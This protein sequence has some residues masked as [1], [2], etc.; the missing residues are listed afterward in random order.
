ML[1]K[2][3]FVVSVFFFLSGC[4]FFDSI[5]TSISGETDFDG[6]VTSVTF[7]STV[8]NV[9][10]NES[11][12]LQLTLS[13]SSNQGKC[14]V[15]WE[16]DENFI[17]VKSDNFG[18]V[19]TGLTA[20]STYIKAKCNG[21]VATCMIS[22]LA[23]GS[24][25]ET[26]PYIYSNYSVI[27][28]KPGDAA[29][30]ISSL[31]GGSISD[32]EFF[33]WS[34]KDS[35]VADISYSRNNCIITAKKTGSTQLVCSHPD[36]KYD[37]SFVIY[38][39]A[40]KM[41]ETYIT[42]DYNVVTINKNE[43]SSKSITVD[44]VNPLNAA[45]KNG[46]VWNYA[47]E[48]SKKIIS[49]T[50][51]LNE[52]VI[53]PQS[54]GIAKII[55]NHENSQYSLEIIIRVC[56]IVKNTYIGLTQTSLI[57][58][59][60]DT[61]YTVYASVENYDGYADA[62]AF[63]WEFP[64]EAEE[65][66]DFSWAGNSVRIQGKKNGCVKIKVSHPLS[67]YSRNLL[68]ILQNQ[69]GSAKDASMYI[70]TTQNYVQTQ[71]GKEPTVINCTLVGG[72][73]GEDD[74]GD[75]SS[76][77]TWWI[78]GGEN[79]GIIEVQAVTGFVKDTSA[80]SAATSGN[81]CSAS[82]Q[83]NPV[84]EGTVK[85]YI[86]HP[87]CL[88]ETEITVKVFA[89]SAI[90]N[91]L[92]ITT[93]ESLVR[94]V[95]GNST[96]IT[97][98][99]R[100]GS[101]GDE[102]NIQWSSSDEEK[103]FLSN[104]TGSQTELI[105]YSGTGNGQTYVTA[106]LE[107]A[108]SDKK[109]L[110]LTADTE[111]ELY[112]MKGIYADS[113]YVRVTSGETKEISVEGFGLVSTDIISWASSDSSLCVVTAESS[114]ANRCIARVTGINEGKVNVTAKIGTSASVVF[115]VTVLKEGESSEIYDE[116]AGY[117]TTALNAVVLESEDDS[118]ELS[119]TG[120]NITDADMALY[121]VWTSSDVNSSEEESIFN[122]Y[123]S[124]G[125][126]V[127]LTANKKGKANLTVK[128]KNAVN[129]L[130]INAKCG[131]LYEW[132]DDYVIYIVSDEDVVNIVNGQTYTIGCSLVNTTSSGSF[133]WKVIRGSDNVDI[134][135]LASGTCSITGKQ[136]GQ[137]IIEVTNTLSGGITK[138]ILIN[139]SNTEEEL[140]GF[141]YLTTEQNVV[142]VG[143]QS[144]SSISVSIVNSDS[145][146]LSG[147][148]WRSTNE[149]VA[150]VVG[151]GSVAV[152]YGKAIGT[153]KIIV[154]N[155]E[156]C[157]Y[158]LE[159]ICNVV[160]PVAVKADPYISCNNI[161]T[162][163]VGGDYATVAAELVGGTD[164]DSQ[165]F[166][167]S[168]TDSAVA[169][170]YSSNDS[171]QIKALKEGVTQ[172]IISHPKA[173]VPRT[174]LVICEPKIT[175]NCYIS[176]AESIIKMS[177]SDEAKTI[178][179]ELVNGDAQ[180]VYDFKWWADSYDKI[181]M[182]YTGSSCLI[183]PLSSGTVT[184]H[185]SHPK[186]ANQ[187]DII[188]YIS[189]YTYFAF[190]ASSVELT[191]GSSYFINMEVP[192]TNVECEIAYSSS[193]NSVCTVFGNSSVCTL[194]PGDVEQG[195]SKT[196]VITATLQTKGGVKQAQAQL[197]VSVTGKDATKPYIALYPDSLSTIITMNKG[198]KKNL[199]AVLYGS[200]VVD[201][202]YA[203][204]NWSVN[205]G[206]GTFI[207]FVA[208]KNT[209]SSV[210]IEAVA[211][212]KTTITVTHSE[213]KNPL[214]LYV[215][216]NGVSEPTV[217]L[218]YTELPVYIGEN[219]QTLTAT[220]QNDAG[221]ELIWTV[222]NDEDGSNSQ[223]YFDFTV[224][225]SK[226]SIYA[227]NPGT[228]TV[229]VSLPSGS[230]ASCRVRILESE[231]IVF[232][233][234]DDEENCTYDESAKTI[235]ED[236][237]TKKY[238]T[239]LQLYPGQS[240][241]LHWE[242]VPAKDTITKWYRSDSNYFEIN[243]VSAGYIDSWTD[244]VSKKTY[245][246]PDG[247]GTVIL[248]GKT[249]EGTAMLQVTTASNQTASVSVTNSYNYLFTTS[250]TI[251]SATP[252]EV[253]KDKTILYVDYELR[254]ACSKIYVTNKTVTEAG[255]N[256]VLESG[257]ASYDK[258]QQ[259]WV[260]ENHETTEETS[261]TG[262]VKGKLKFAIE[263][264]ANCT[265]EVF[266]RN[267]N[268]VSSGSASSSTS[269]DDFGKSNIK[270]QVYYSSHTFI[271]EIVKQVP[272]YN[273]TV[274]DSDEKNSMYSEFDSQSNTFFLGDGE[275]LS[276]TIKVD[277]EKEP[278]S[279]VLITGIKF[280]PVN[281]SQ[282]KDSSD[283]SSGKS[284]YELVF[285]EENG[286]VVNEHPFVLYHNTDYALI[287]YST[288]GSSFEKKTKCYKIPDGDSRA[289]SENYNETVKETSFVGYLTVSYFNYAKG[290]GEN[291]Y[292]FPVYVRVRNCPCSINNYYLRSATW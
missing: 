39:Y 249:N 265:V 86:S 84:G 225:G 57:I 45:Y 112:S 68:V 50:S 18:A 58:D 232:F 60:S 139:V 246:Y 276:G 5:E 237:R 97:A 118:A 193:D 48:E 147:Y 287:Y 140:N 239:F 155:N 278:Y 23:D 183:K 63:I 190:A 126:S 12:Y 260:I 172:V 248:T 186:A 242:T 161:V 141:K 204:L 220:V 224:S 20:G 179:A 156:Y 108:L 254:P 148:S 267:E 212:G 136:A 257:Y 272:Y 19:I 121:T 177:P 28:L 230:S 61:P 201:T 157:S 32:M 233:V 77:F 175:T 41:T 137:S 142:T 173:S 240:K 135:G 22:V 114:S 123:G 281:S 275:L 93:D 6:K 130:S 14:N 167:W 285:G 158:P 133:S 205:N 117:L 34:I 194:N 178:T 7:S 25:A 250:K 71:V 49:L 184:L 122:I 76:N 56:T 120:V 75:D 132:T 16:Y 74:V 40:D 283:N 150:T 176:L 67:E 53:T 166:S 223:D 43:T 198:E 90:V 31:Y 235:T 26:E 171:A 2:S 33:E 111:E 94:L 236:K 59:G 13:P 219:T 92:T 152:V 226:A 253:H 101:Y 151:S 174:V 168:I 65:L 262:I 143:E 100:N 8:M 62:D 36:A 251:V 209:G 15:Y 289:L 213:A 9:N 221:E 54:N 110:V 129:S 271:P 255:K 52:A 210:Q 103:V 216:V 195:V 91:P 197:L 99:L 247:V 264:E 55:V 162:C 29:T 138:E 124:P 256:L 269:Y 98:T 263:G 208:D 261:S 46:F 128:N 106:H 244:Q 227:N 200:G 273:R 165:N 243:S 44:L 217:T 241:P 146:I 149:S 203:G 109:I 35:A 64:S 81:Y 259:Q 268:V 215:I 104:K 202:N 4:H 277:E 95:N 282:I 180:D 291:T 105:T 234:Y 131:E 231:K 222:T 72:I 27:E 3:L 73:E 228:A 125:S 187:K 96:A 266:A 51:N 107:G 69:L 47:D 87:K 82:M 182:N 30:V 42:T 163:T 37:Y 280:N 192:A 38:V 288:D 144:N 211:S 127:K 274:Y 279:N 284:Q 199:Q 79:N 11:E 113:T 191:T 102:E 229:T 170:L 116:N 80:R 207:E 181:D 188:L 88:Y 78:D 164:G 89:E 159:I 83:I 218:N 258:E 10:K 196:C 206:S 214:T 185:V 24:E 85:I 238:I 189:N 1:K 119:V 17:S 154:E 115:D 292:S 160:D 21:I 290:S 153:A 145:N 134:V 66:M 169:S 70:T 245:Y 252:L 270:F 286:A